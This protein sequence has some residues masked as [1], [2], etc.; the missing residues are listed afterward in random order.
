MTAPESSPAAT[1]ITTR[2]RQAVNAWRARVLARWRRRPLLTTLGAFLA[3]ALLLG[4]GDLGV[5]YARLDRFGVDV[6][7]LTTAADAAG[8]DAPETWLVIGTDSR[9]DLPDGPDRYGGVED[10][11]DGARADVAALVQPTAAGVNVLVLPRDLTVAQGQLFDERLATSF[12]QGPQR[13][14][15]ALCSTYGIATAHVVT[16]DMSQFAGIVDSLGGIDVDIDEPVRDTYSGLEIGTAGPQHLNGVDALALVRSRHPEVQR[17]GQ[18]VALSEQEGAERRSHFTGVVMRCVISALLERSHNPLTLQSLAWTLT[19]NLGVDS[20]TGL[21]DLAR[22]A[23]AVSDSGEGTTAAVNLVEV[24]A[25]PVGDGFAA[26]PTDQTYKTLAAYG[27]TP[28]T[29]APAE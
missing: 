23:R 16:V 10:V 28:G 19:G 5:L 15:D 6:P 12:L 17:N 9:T 11:G 1:S 21:L 13:T 25:G 8:A 26:P 3:A 24:P 2:A 20:G 4:I 7:S 29:C 22:L 14:V 27:Y 18:W